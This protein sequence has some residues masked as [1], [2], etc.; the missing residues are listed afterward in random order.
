MKVVYI[1]GPP[2]V[3]RDNALKLAL[4]WVEQEANG[5]RVN[6]LVVV[7]VR[8]SPGHSDVLSRIVGRYQWETARTLRASAAHASVMLAVWPSP[9]TLATIRD[10]RPHAVCVV[11]W[12][13]EKTNDWLAAHSAEDLSGRASPLPAPAIA[14]PIVRVAVQDLTRSINLGN[15]LYQPED[16]DLAVLTLHLLHQHG[17]ALDPDELYRWAIANGWPDEG[18]ENLRKLIREVLDGRRHRV[19]TR[20][21]L[22]DDAYRYRERKAT[23]I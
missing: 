17:H 16:H 1:P 9:D 14:D 22:K 13:D 2:R 3:E 7:P 11:Q 12:T 6:V 8:D 10:L 23:E 15:R 21:P 20:A 18:A 19:R 5:R 4:R